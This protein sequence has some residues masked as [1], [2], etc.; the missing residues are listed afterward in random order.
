MLEKEVLDGTE[1]RFCD[2]VSAA[3]KAA[4][5][6]GDRDVHASRMEAGSTGFI[7]MDSSLIFFMVVTKKRR[8]EN[9]LVTQ[10]KSADQ[11]LDQRHQNILRPKE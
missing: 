6:S 7:E 10:G 3:I 4:R 11:L 1:L 8:K 5:T 9:C 2:K